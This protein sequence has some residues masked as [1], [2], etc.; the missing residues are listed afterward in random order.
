[1]KNIQV[2]DGA[3]N[4]TFSIFQVTEEEFAQIFPDDGQDIEFAEDFAARLGNHAAA[5]M[6]PIWDRPIKKRDAVGIYGTLYYQFEK[7]RKYFPS[8]KCEK[9]WDWSSI[10][11]AQ[12]KMYRGDEGPT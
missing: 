8:S 5:V 12:R 11:A 7:R 1:M 4:C 6:T 9:D 10:N 3:G 2:I